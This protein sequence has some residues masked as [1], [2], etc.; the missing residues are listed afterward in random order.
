MRIAMRMRIMKCISRLDVSKLFYFV[1][2]LEK[3]EILWKLIIFIMCLLLSI[4]Q[5][6]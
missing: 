4:S 2:I 3:K 5:L 1:N 6:P